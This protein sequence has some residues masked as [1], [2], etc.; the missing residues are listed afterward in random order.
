M[1]FNDCSYEVGVGL[2]YNSLGPSLGHSVLTNN[3]SWPTTQPY[4]RP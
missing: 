3:R 1:F 4:F 2:T